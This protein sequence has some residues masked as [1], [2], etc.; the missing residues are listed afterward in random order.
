MVKKALDND[1][2][3]AEI[4][5]IEASIVQAGEEL[6]QTRE[7]LKTLR[8]ERNRLGSER[9]KLTRKLNKIKNQ[10]GMLKKLIWQSE[11][12]EI[13]ALRNQLLLATKLVKE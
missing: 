1:V 13:V 9:A 6:E 12:P 10:P 3:L 7:E 4:R 2:A 5:A 11:D 8:L